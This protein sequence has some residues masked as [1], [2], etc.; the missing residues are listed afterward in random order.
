M[1][2]TALMIDCGEIVGIAD[3]GDFYATLLMSVAEGKS[4][5]L[6]VSKVERIDGAALQ[7]MYAYSKEARSHG[8]TL[9]WHSPSEAFLRSARLLGLSSLMNLENT[10]DEVSQ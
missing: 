10:T 2:E 4:L 8:H 5:N 7:L 3:V 1:A 6:D 9:S